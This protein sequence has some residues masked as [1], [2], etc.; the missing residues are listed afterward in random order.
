MNTN[1][2]NN[3]QM[4]FYISFLSAELPSQIASKRFGPD[5]WIPF[6]V[7]V[8]SLVTLCQAFT[9]G[10]TTFFI[11]RALLGLS[12][13]GLIPDMVLYLS[14]WYKTAELPIRLSWFWATLSTSANFALPFGGP[15]FADLHITC[16]PIF[17]SHQD[18]RLSTR[19]WTA[20]PPRPPWLGRLEVRPP[21]T[22]SLTSLT[23]QAEL[24]SVRSTDTSSSSKV[25]SPCRL[26]S[27][28]SST[29][30]PLPPRP[31]RASGAETAG[32]R[33]AKRRSWSTAS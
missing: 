21:S 26:E 33:L 25:V 31:R 2:Y 15:P 16:L 32:S 12:E 7:M 1:D 19:R 13:G 6:Q 5:R 28:P 22:R 8:W 3:G 18:H 17:S 29:C 9:N 23:T 30:R 20:C 11:T 27:S 10:R 14:Y 4:I 24:G